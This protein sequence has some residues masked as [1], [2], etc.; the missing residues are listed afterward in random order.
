MAAILQAAVG[1]DQRWTELLQHHFPIC[2]SNLGDALLSVLSYIAS[3]A[4]TLFTEISKDSNTNP[5]HEMQKLFRQDR[6]EFVSV[7]SVFQALGKVKKRDWPYWCRQRNVS[8]AS[9]SQVNKAYLNLKREIQSMRTEQ[10]PTI[11][12]TPQPEDGD[13]F[14]RLGAL[15]L[16]VFPECL[17]MRWHTGP[18]YL[19]CATLKSKAMQQYDLDI[20]ENLK[21]ELPAY[22]LCLPDGN[23]KG[24]PEA[25]AA[26]NLSLA[27]SESVLK[28]SC[29]LP[30][31]TKF[32]K[33]RP[34][35][36]VQ[37]QL[38]FM[39]DAVVLKLAGNE[40]AR[41]EF[42]KAIGE[43]CSQEDM[44]LSLQLHKP[45]DTCSRWKLELY[46][47]A[48]FQ[49]DVEI[50]VGER[51]YVAMDELKC[52]AKTVPYPDAE[53]KVKLMVR[54]GGEVHVVPNGQHLVLVHMLKDDEF[55]PLAQRDKC[56]AYKRMKESYLKKELLLSG[57]VC[58]FEKS[59]EFPREPL[60]AAAW[61]ECRSS[62][63]K[64]KE[65]EGCGGLFPGN[66]REKLVL[67]DN[68]APIFALEFCFCKATIQ[69]NKLKLQF[70][71]LRDL[72]KFKKKI[73]LDDSIPNVEYVFDQDE[74]N[75]VITSEMA[76]MNLMEE[77]CAP[78]SKTVCPKSVTYSLRL[79]TKVTDDDSR[80]LQRDLDFGEYFMDD[81]LLETR[82]YPP[83]DGGQVT[84]GVFLSYSLSGLT[85]LTKLNDKPELCQGVFIGQKVYMLFT[86]PK[87]AYSK[88]EGGLRSLGMMGGNPPTDDSVANNGTDNLDSPVVRARPYKDKMDVTIYVGNEV[89]DS[90]KFK[91]V[92]KLMKPLIVHT[93]SDLLAAL[94]SVSEESGQTM[95]GHIME[96]TD[97]YIQI[98]EE[99]STLHVYG[100]LD[101]KAKADDRITNILSAMG[102][103][104]VT[105]TLGGFGEGR[106]TRS[107]L[108]KDGMCV[109][110]L[111]RVQGREFRLSLC[112]HTY[113]QS[114]FRDIV[115][116]AKETVTFPIRCG[117]GD[118]TQ[119]V[120]I[121]D[122]EAIHVYYDLPMTDFYTSSMRACKSSFPC[123]TTGCPMRFHECK[124]WI[125]GLVKSF[126][127]P[128]CKETWCTSCHCE[129]HFGLSCKVYQALKGANRRLK[130]W[131]N[132]K[133]ALRKL[134]PR[135]LKGIENLD[136]SAIV[137]C[138]RCKIKICW[139]CLQYHH[140]LSMKRH[141]CSPE[142]AD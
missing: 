12:Q 37:V 86:V 85:E 106:M 46:C 57:E 120:L 36:P 123:L 41:K 68:D 7:V 53:S 77:F 25:P 51:M 129:F 80:R 82:V 43:A 115:L 65:L 42:E 18:K 97:T 122:I 138:A 118:C 52:T 102:K 81:F 44:L 10:T 56:P 92:P 94:L 78:H 117:K 135:C 98:N 66:L 121:A 119:P 133:K 64:A 105:A 101:N 69:E 28:A 19:N 54:P 75:V 48:K 49:K 136:G 22:M 40:T 4:P 131:I 39:G 88:L 127:C 96:E 140:Y 137:G 134:C 67:V 139:H 132:K 73:N 15:V 103:D 16:K 116:S 33:C 100:G 111:C 47:P 31:K 93:R 110:C 27:V 142:D 63:I 124:S 24:E 6:G 11:E 3:G 112:G 91:Q 23:K 14:D 107:S 114:C 126:T 1:I 95:L 29:F 109:V 60:W 83:D 84:W 13:V 89:Y 8:H 62:G 26:M 71:C 17:S 35:L 59:K 32:P 61:Y 76:Y 128:F 5:Q 130:K 108:Q 45:N 90:S 99:D 87:D 74:L 21:A 72:N 55:V 2:D 38:P 58:E 30:V 113:C 79:E 50:V 125:E 34:H 70:D 9:L 20:L 141:E 104:D